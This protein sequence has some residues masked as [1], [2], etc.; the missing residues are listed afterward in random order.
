[1]NLAAAARAEFS[2]ICYCTRSRFLIR[3]PEKEAL[4]AS[5]VA[6]RPT[7]ASGSGAAARAAGA[8]SAS[9]KHEEVRDW[10]CSWRDAGAARV[11]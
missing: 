1:M 10:H 8:E 9:G 4:R 11:M 3:Q 5:R 7:Q 6:P 2:I